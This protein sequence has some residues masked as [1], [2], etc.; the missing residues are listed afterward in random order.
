MDTF[1]WAWMK[2]IKVVYIKI[3]CSIYYDL[4]IV[5]KSKWHELNIIP[6]PQRIY[7]NSKW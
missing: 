2:K 7:Y 1:W 3:A 6:D 5:K 4:F